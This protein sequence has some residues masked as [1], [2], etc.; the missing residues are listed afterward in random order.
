[1]AATFAEMARVH[2]G[3]EVWQQDF[4][5]LDLPPGR[6][7]CFFASSSLFHVPR[8]ELPRVR[9]ELHTTLATDGILFSSN[10]HG[11]NEEGWNRGR[12][13]SYHDPRAWRRYGEQAGFIELAS[14]YRPAGLPREQ[15]P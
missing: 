8:S 10:P 15:Q 9:R 7:E 6:F 1:G 12:F 5:R 3:C 14:Y 13:G 11:N 4:L 2:S